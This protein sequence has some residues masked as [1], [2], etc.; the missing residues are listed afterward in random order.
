MSNLELARLGTPRVDAER[1]IDRAIVVIAAILSFGAAAIHFAAVQPH[2]EEF[3]PF[4]VAFAFLGVVQLVLGVG[5]TRGWP[6][7]RT[8]SV[9]VSLG[10]IAVWV[11]SRTAGLPI[12]PEPWTPEEIGP[13]DVISSTFEA[14]M[15]AL[16]VAAP[17]YRTLPGRIVRGLARSVYLALVPISGGVTVI[18]LIAVAALLGESGADHGMAM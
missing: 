1:V 18:T 11:M 2:L 14:A 7:A 6:A 10:V 4:A 17:L 15:V 9:L 12:G 13:A 16:L 5:L 8:T 3:V